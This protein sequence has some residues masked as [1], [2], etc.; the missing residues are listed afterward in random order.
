MGRKLKKPPRISS[1]AAIKRAENEDGLRNHSIDADNPCR[2]S[3]ID[4]FEVFVQ[5]GSRCH[6]NL[7]NAGRWLNAPGM[8]RFGWGKS[9]DLANHP[10]VGWAPSASSVLLQTRQER[11]ERARLDGITERPFD[12]SSPMLNIKYTNSRKDPGSGIAQVQGMYPLTDG[13][14]R[15]GR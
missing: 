10:H 14:R 9:P 2:L 3:P 12:T 13:V 15:S 11:K 7:I 8:Q 5:F 6:A 4:H 1:S